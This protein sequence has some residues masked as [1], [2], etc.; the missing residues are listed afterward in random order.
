[1]IHEYWNVAFVPLVAVGA[2]LVGARLGERSRP[3]VLVAAGVLAAF[4][5]ASAMVAAGYSTDDGA[6]WAARNAAQ[7]GTDTLYSTQRTSDW[8]T[9]ESGR[10][11][12]HVPSCDELE[13]TAAV[14]P[15]AD[16]LTSRSW[17]ES[18][19]GNWESVSSGAPLVTDDGYAVVTA[20]T[21]AGVC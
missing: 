4:V 15:D 5:V 17:T 16:V 20:R 14:D 13:E 12:G 1:V 8:I 6:G 3:G 7:H 10:P 9:Y 2:A 21:L 19:G 11:S 18:V